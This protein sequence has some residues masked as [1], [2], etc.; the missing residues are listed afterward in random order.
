[1]KEKT[2]KVINTT[3]LMSAEWRFLESYMPARNISWSTHTSKTYRGPSRLKRARAR[4]AAVAEARSALKKNEKALLVSHLPN[5]AAATNAARSVI[6]PKVP[7]IAFSFNFTTLP[8]GIARHGYRR[9]LRNID[10]VVVFSTFERGLYADWL[11]IPIEKIRFLKWA[12]DAPQAAPPDHGGIE[13][14]PYLCSIGGE[15]RDDSLLAEVMR[16]LPQHRA[17]IIARPYSIEGIDFPDNVEVKLNLPSDQTWRIALDSVGLA[18]PLLS[19]DTAC[20]HITFAGGQL[21]GIPILTTRT[22]GLADYLADGD[23]FGTMQAGRVDD[24]VSQI[25]TLFEDST[26]AKTQ[27]MALVSKAESMYSPKLLAEY[28]H[29]VIERL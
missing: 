10:E 9:F 24:A 12:M 8:Q 2:C 27:A 17:V 28:F 23:V 29:G 22:H 18:L 21:L 14:Q 16:K 4:L 5:M 3:D 7:Q 1:M 25:E 13:L 19:E 11:D 15:A 20:G 26:E 6:A